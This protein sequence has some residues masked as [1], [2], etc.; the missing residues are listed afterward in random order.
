M[1]G[2]LPESPLGQVVSLRAENDK[3]RLKA[4]NKVQHEIRN[5]WRRSVN[6]ELINSMSEKEKRKSVSD[7]QTV[8]KQMFSV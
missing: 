1:N 3:E 5:K 2:L 7:I 8:F 4:F 6:Q